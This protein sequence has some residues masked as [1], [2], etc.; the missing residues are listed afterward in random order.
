LGSAILDGTETLETLA[1]RVA[2]GAIDPR[3]V[4]GAQEALENVV[5]QSIWATDAS[6]VTTPTGR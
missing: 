4:S 1:S 5:N 2:S 6:R 3:P